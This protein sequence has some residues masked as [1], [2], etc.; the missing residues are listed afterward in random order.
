M[1]KN[2]IQPGEVLDHVA[3]AAI[4]SGQVV[5]LGLRIGVALG[6]AAI[7]ATVA[8]QVKG[9]FNLPKVT[10]NVVTQGALLYWDNT[11]KLLTTVPTANTLAGYA[12]AAASGT[13]T[14]VNI[15]LNA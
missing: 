12:T 13:A 15:S 2:Y 11:A 4:I 10:A 8:V 14:T 5:L 6:N 1:A 9:V 7:G 3:A